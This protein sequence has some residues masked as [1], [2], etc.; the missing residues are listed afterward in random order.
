MNTTIITGKIYSI[1]LTVGLVI[2]LFGALKKILHRP[3]AD[4]F[5]SVSFVFIAL[6][7]LIGAYEVFSSKRIEFLEKALWLGGF[8]FINAITAIVYLAVGRKRVI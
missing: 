1:S 6:Y 2:L 7:T 3:D 8:L 4:T 5:L